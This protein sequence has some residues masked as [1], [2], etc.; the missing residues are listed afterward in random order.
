MHVRTGRKSKQAHNAYLI[1]Y[2]EF[3]GSYENTS[4]IKPLKTQWNR[5]WFNLY[6]KFL[7][8]AITR[9]QVSN[10]SGK[11]TTKDVPHYNI[12]MTQPFC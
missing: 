9:F 8:G 2:I 3:T 11:N 4:N 7:L 12:A 6:D 1:L 5:M 10:M